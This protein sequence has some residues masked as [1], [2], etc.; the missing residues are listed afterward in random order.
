[1]NKVSVPFAWLSLACGLLGLFSGAVLGLNIARGSEPGSYTVHYDAVYREFHDFARPDD[2]M[3]VG[4][5]M[6]RPGGCADWEITALY[7]TDHSAKDLCEYYSKE[8]ETRGWTRRVDPGCD[9]LSPGVYQVDGDLPADDA[10]V[11]VRV[12][13]RPT[14]EQAEIVPARLFIDAKRL[15]KQLF[16]VRWSISCVQAACP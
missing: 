8:M 5:S 14:A 10:G 13:I 12:Q 16:S 1:M 15:Q 2:S 11:V 6:C 4:Y 9:R 7:A 3:M